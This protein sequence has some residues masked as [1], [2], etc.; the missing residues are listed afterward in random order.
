MFLQSPNNNTMNFE[1]IP[2]LN[3]ILK[4]QLYLLSSVYEPIVVVPDYNMS[5]N[6]G[7]L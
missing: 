7:S 2:Q 4:E 6:R 1:S 5:R 3:N